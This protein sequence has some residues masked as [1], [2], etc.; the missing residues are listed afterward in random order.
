MRGVYEAEKRLKDR[1]GA[2]LGTDL[3]QAYFEAKRSISIMDEFYDRQAVYEGAKADL[4]NLRRSGASKKDIEDA[5]AAFKDTEEY[6]KAIKK[7]VSSVT[8]SEEEMYKFAAL[9]EHHPE[10]RD[11]MNN[12][13]AIN[14]NLLRVWAQV[15][16]LSMERYK[17]LSSIKD[18]VPWQRIM[19]DDEDPHSPLHSTTRTLANIGRE[20]KFKSGTP[21][22]SL[23]VQAKE[24]QRSFKV[25]PATVVSVEVDGKKVDQDL[26]SVSPAGEVVIDYPIRAGNL[27]VFKVVSPIQNIVE[28]MTQNVMRMTM[29]AIR[30][31][32]ASRIVNEYAT[33]DADGNIMTFSSLSTGKNRF[34]FV[35]NGQRKIVEIQD[36]LVM[37]AI[38]GMGS[39]NAPLDGVA[40]FSA[41]FSNFF[42]R[43][44]TLSGVFQVKQVFKDAPTAA[45]V[46]GVRR[47]FALIGGV[48][49]GLI[50]AL[51]QP[52]LKKLGYNIEP[53][54]DILRA[55]GIGGF[56]TGTRTPEAEVKRRLGMMNNNVFDF[57]IRALDYIGDSSDIAQRVATYKQVM[58]DTGNETQAMYQAANVINFQHHGASAT[59]QA[60]V[61]TVPFSG[62]Y[63]NA[64]DVLVN[65]LLG[66][67]LKGMSRAE[68]LQ[69]L[70]VT[71]ILLS[72]TTLLYRMA[73]GDDPEY[74]ELDDQTK[75]RNFIIPGTDIMLPMNTSA[76]FIFKAIPE[77]VYN[78][79]INE[80]TET[81]IDRTRLKEALARAARD[82]LL[83]P[84]PI[85]QVIKAPVEIALDYNFFTGR[86]L[87]PPNLKNVEA[88]EQ[89]TAATSELGKYIS[90]A[91]ELAGTDGKRLLSPIDAD[92]LVRGMF[93]T[94]AAMV[95]WFSNKIGA[96]QGVRPEPT[97]RETPIT[98][99]FL[100]PQ[101]PRG[102][103]DLFYDLKERVDQKV[104]TLRKKEEE[105]RLAEA[106]AYDKEKAK[107][108][109]M[110]G[111]LNDLAEE[112]ADINAEIREWSSSVYLDQPPAKRRERI[113]ALRREKQ[114]VLKG[115]E[116]MRKDAGL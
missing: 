48:Y 64:T 15:G 63:A 39:I 56:Y 32:A 108:I 44:I 36:D 67:G 82:M 59:A 18:Y 22:T 25:P 86:A 94:T 62:A 79:I 87:T 19:I 102:R 51:L 110:Q 43:T 107:L 11:M 77:M 46:T 49:K 5:E 29:N 7:A 21:I 76:A 105:G 34:Y 70:V 114:D 84:E 91:T 90:A 3:A 112:L 35:I 4:A 83:G 72:F 85:P 61:R 45:M 50:T 28:N 52:G 100:R 101:V 74:E 55:A 66:G 68:A 53:T 89:Y 92:H 12:W 115:I 40:A 6:F 71:T 73:V 26:L 10:L 37:S 24:G 13:T 58:A 42:R 65:A 98:G 54:I 30:Q 23:E 99:A 14:Q 96:A 1:V 111:E 57:V 16:L 109:D 80:G 78:K 93:G 17:T 116:K 9:E 113:E 81:E 60:V 47:P 27:V 104:N 20:K 41:A 95:Q 88:A 69:R 97:A 8:M 33:R 31:Y 106:I 2:Q 38:Y 103:E 75:L